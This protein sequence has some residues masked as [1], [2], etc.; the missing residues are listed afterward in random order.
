MQ[1][2]KLKRWIGIYIGEVY[3]GNN[4]VFG[5]GVNIASRIQSVAV[6]GTVSIYYVVASK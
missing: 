2:V 4:D 6:P 3:T 5:D 1:N